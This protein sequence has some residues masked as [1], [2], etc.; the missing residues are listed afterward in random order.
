[1]A[2]EKL[3]SVISMQKAVEL[4]QLRIYGQNSDSDLVPTD[5]SEINIM[6]PCCSAE[7]TSQ[8]L[9]LNINF[10]RGVFGCPRC[11]FS[12]GVYK[13]ISHYTGWPYSEVEGRIKQGEFGAFVPG[14]TPD[15]GANKPIEDV[16]RPMAPLKQRHDVYTALLDMLTLSDAHKAN[17]L[18]R[19][20]N[21]E[22]IQRI[23]FKS[24][25]KYID[26]TVIPKKLISAGLD[27]RGVPGFGI[28]DS[29]EWSMAKL[30]D[31]GFMIP[32]RNGQQLIQGFQIR[33]DHPND[34]IPKFGYLTSGGMTGG[35]KAST[36]CSWAGEDL[37]HRES[38]EPFDVILIEGGLKAYIVNEISGSNVLAVPGVSTLKKVPAALQSMVAMGLRCVYIAY[39][40]DQ[41][42]NEQVAK[43]LNRLRHI[44]DGLHIEHQTMMW[45]PEFKGLDD[46]IVGPE[47]K[48]LL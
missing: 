14:Q 5:V 37:I 23:G 20:L 7:H 1:M 34:K 38:P 10:E 41:E 45:N 9:T 21:E 33:F 6:C 16:G 43:Q 3:S 19:G 8:R 39:D 15:V 2:K 4:L 31:G 42:T 25:P 29:H 36:W 24:Y 27:L 40:M 46:W 28:N 18:K 13:L 47:F 11:S 22:A 12:G 30:P 44:L 35:T 17:L 32:S 48:K 26:P